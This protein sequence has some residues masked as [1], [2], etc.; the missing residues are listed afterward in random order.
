MEGWIKLHRK[1]ENWE[2]FN[3][4]EMVHLFIYLLLS[5]NSEDGNWRGISVKRGQ[6]ITG[7]TSLSENTG[8]SQQT[9]R[10]CLNRL[11]STNEI[12]I[13][14][15][16]Q[17]SIITIIKYEDY[18]SKKLNSNQPTN[19]PPTQPL[20]SDQPAT[21]HKQEEEEYKKIEERKELFLQKVAEIGTIKYEQQMLSDFCNYWTEANMK[22]G[23][24]RFEM[25]KVFELP[26]RLAYWNS[27]SKKNNDRVKPIFTEY[28]FK[29]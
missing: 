16:N 15:T 1:F 14:S 17:Y 19:Q 10:T 24:M 2:W 13:Q 28:D 9:I 20:T 25:E 23:K 3:I 8:I 21:N 26:N 18:Q 7:R 27:R 4:S 6:L 12:T 5:A 11:K 29:K 22:K